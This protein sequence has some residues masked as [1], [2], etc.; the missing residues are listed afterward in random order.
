M[1]DGLYKSIITLILT[2]VRDNCLSAN[3]LMH[4]PTVNHHYPTHRYTPLNMMW[5]TRIKI[6][7][8]F[9]VI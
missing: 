2:Q 1:L 7:E 8:H 4:Y 3:V 5:P 6:S 9:G